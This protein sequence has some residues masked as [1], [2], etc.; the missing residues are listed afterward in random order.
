MF[1]KLE[2]LKSNIA[3]GKRR[4]GGANGKPNGSPLPPPG[5]PLPPPPLKAAVEM[6]ATA[7]ADAPAELI[8]SATDAAGKL[9]EAESA[10]RRLEGQEA[11]LSR[12]LEDCEGQLDVC[13][14]EL[15]AATAK[16]KPSQSRLAGPS[17]DELAG[18]RRRR[19]TGPEHRRRRS[20]DQLA[21]NDAFSG[22]IPDDDLCA[23]VTMG[24]TSGS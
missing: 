5:S 21:S 20:S 16:C 10:L 8:A 2:R 12:L 13:V 19:R 4:D 17:D 22:I 11:M 18:Y 14:R 15:N 3:L 9:V 6:N 24:W 7:L 1:D 23:D